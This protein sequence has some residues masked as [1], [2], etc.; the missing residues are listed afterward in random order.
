MKILLFT[1]LPPPMHGSNYMSKLFSESASI[2]QH[3]NLKTY[4]AS[5]VTKLEDI[6]KVSFYKLLKMVKH[7][8]ALIYLSLSFRPD[9]VIFI[10][11]FNSFSFVRDFLIVFTSKKILYNKNILWIH[12]NNIKYLFDNSG[13]L[14]KWMIKE[15]FNCSNKIIPC[16]IKLPQLNYYFFSEPHKIFPIPNGMP[17]NKSYFREHT[18][19][20]KINV[21]FISNMDRLK[22]W[23][24]LFEAAK[25]ICRKYGNIEFLFAGSPSS[26]SSHEFISSTFSESGFVERIRYL[27]AQYGEDKEIL[28]KKADIFCFP[29]DYPPESFGLVILEAMAFCLPVIT[30]EKGRIADLIIDG[31]GG[32][33]VNKN[34]PKDLAEKLEILINDKELRLK[35]GEFNRQRYLENFTFEKFEENWINFFN[36]IS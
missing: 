27:G 10:P 11:A 13:L 14:I 24:T 31:K 3:I 33:I 2:N 21:L 4:N 28:F 30:T 17:L 15:L 5:Y 6:G 26:D 25:I 22:G 29:T 34:D 16:A 36:T 23:F 7:F 12:T 18:D 9:Y 20:D 8:F 32:F 1:P 19:C 35:M